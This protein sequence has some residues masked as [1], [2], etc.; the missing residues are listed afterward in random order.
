MRVVTPAHR[1]II[2][3]DHI[4]ADA[5]R[6]AADMLQ[7]LRADD[8]HLPH[9]WNAPAPDGA[10]MALEDRLGRELTDSEFAAYSLAFTVAIEDAAHARA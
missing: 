6:A 5:R 3:P 8:R 7:R 10:V 1:P 2:V 9:R 4:A